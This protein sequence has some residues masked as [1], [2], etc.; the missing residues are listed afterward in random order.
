MEL[1]LI[2]SNLI[3]ELNFNVS[4]VKKTLQN[5]HLKLAISRNL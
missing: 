4:S 1:N 2:E 3:M 5:I